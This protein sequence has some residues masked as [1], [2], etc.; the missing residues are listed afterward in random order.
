MTAEW[1]LLGQGGPESQRGQ[2]PVPGRGCVVVRVIPP[3]ADV[4]WGCSCVGSVGPVSRTLKPAALTAGWSLAPLHSL[5]GTREYFLPRGRLHGRCLG[6]TVEARRFVQRASLAP[7]ELLFPAGD[8]V[9]AQKAD[10]VTPLVQ[11]CSLP[12]MLGT[13]AGSWLPTTSHSWGGSAHEPLEMTLKSLHLLMCPS[14]PLRPPI[15]LSVCSGHT[16]WVCAVRSRSV[17]RCMPANTS[18][19]WLAPGRPLCRAVHQVRT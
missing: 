18:T 7:H 17:S 4:R 16:S 6:F 12:K 13:K 8:S 2:H 19:S 5:K 9:S 15:P 11:C 3:P 10:F 14:V 1:H